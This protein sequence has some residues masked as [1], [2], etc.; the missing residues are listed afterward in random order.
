MTDDP[1]KVS[2][3]IELTGQCLSVV[4]FISEIG[5]DQEAW[6]EGRGVRS[7]TC[8]LPALLQEIGV[9]AGRGLVVR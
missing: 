8:E 7:E 4:P 1:P 2:R 5:T 3:D 6:E 9:R